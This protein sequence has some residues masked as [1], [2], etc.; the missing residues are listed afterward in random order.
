MGRLVVHVPWYIQLDLQL[1]PLQ[2]DEESVPVRRGDL[3]GDFRWGD[4]LA[5][6]SLHDIFPTGTDSNHSIAP[7]DLNKILYKTQFESICQETVVICSLPRNR[8]KQLAIRVAVD[9]FRAP[10]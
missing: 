1:T 7:A 10:Y 3:R 4:T 5:R 8:Y 6:V 2:G 9:T